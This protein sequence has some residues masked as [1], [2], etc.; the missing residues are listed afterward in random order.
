[1][2][3]LVL[4]LVVMSLFTLALY[5]IQITLFDKFSNKENNFSEKKVVQVIVLDD[6]IEE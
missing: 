4:L 2:G 1:M 5:S 3:L 6:T